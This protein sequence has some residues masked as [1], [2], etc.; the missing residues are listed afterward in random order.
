MPALGLAQPLGI[1]SPAA[2]STLPLMLRINGN[3]VN[4]YVP[5]DSYQ[6]TDM[7]FGSPQQLSFD[8]IDT[9]NAIG[10]ILLGQA[11]VQWSD[12]VAGTMLYQ[13]YIKDVAG[14]STA[15]YVHWTVTCNDLSE[16][17]DFARPVIAFTPPTSQPGAGQGTTA[18]ISIQS[19]LA[20]Y[21]FLPNMGTGGFVQTLGTVFT[22]NQIQMST[23]RSAIDQIL[24]ATGVA[25]AAYYVDAYGHLHVINTGDTTAPFAIGATVTGSSGGG[26]TV[27]TAGR[28]TATATANNATVTATN[29]APVSTFYLHDA[30]ATNTGTMPS[31]VYTGEVPDGAAISA[32]VVRAMDGSVGASQ[33]SVAVADNATTSPQ[34]WIMRTFVSGS[35]AAQTIAAQQYIITCGLQQSNADSNVQITGTAYVWR[36]SSATIVGL[37]FFLQNGTGISGTTEQAAS[38]TIT[39]PNT[40]AVTAQSGDI[41]VYELWIRPVHGSAS[42]YTDTVYYDGTTI[43]STTTNAATLQLTNAVTLQSG[44][45]GIPSTGFAAAT[46]TAYNASTNVGLVIVQFP[47]SGAN[48][49]AAFLTM[50]ADLTNDVIEMA[51]GTYAWT[52]VAI[53]INRS[54][55]PL[56]IRPAS[57]ATVTF[58]G[59]GLGSGTGVF[60]IGADSSNGGNTG[61]ASY[62]TFAGL[63]GGVQQFVIQNYTIGQTGLIYTQWIS[64]VEISGFKVRTC[65]GIAATSHCLYISSDGSH[66]PDHVIANDWDVDPD[67]GSRNITGLQ[68]YHPPQ[69]LTFTA[70]RWTINRA[71]WGFVGRY[72]ATGVTIAN[73][74]VTNTGKFDSSSGNTGIVFDCQG[75]AG[76]V[77]NMTSTGSPAGTNHIVQSPMVEGSGNSWA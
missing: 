45:G 59:T 1:S 14:V 77:S 18:G 29:T 46:G 65:H 24:G 26:A 74:T 2:A 30:F 10:S 76:T 3:V 67:A 68:L 20:Q 50:V 66:A 40:S 16:A 37:L 55:R 70:L 47:G 27:V 32:T 12:E 41:L 51:N 71:F 4:K 22:S 35:L 31:G 5:V 23:L 21:S 17:L 63:V 54:S 53:N 42:S 38:F 58:D 34:D 44:G 33:V 61:L 75:P 49:T 19:L 11:L 8:V 7:G 28:A 48:T 25:N 64:H 60:Y 6:L 13:G 15:P 62:I 56:I 43:G 9:T 57:G 52:D 39:S 72:S 73:W 36:P 69:V